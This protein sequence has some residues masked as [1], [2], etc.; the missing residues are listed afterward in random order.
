MGSRK[1]LFAMFTSVVIVA[2]SRFVPEVTFSGAVMGLVSVCGI[3]VGGNAASRWVYGHSDAQKV[4]SAT[5]T[6]IKQGE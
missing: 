3:Y 4:E 1:F 5:P 6:K 2:S